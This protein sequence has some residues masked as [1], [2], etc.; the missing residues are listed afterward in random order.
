MLLVLWGMLFMAN[1]K[2]DN[3]INLP[4]KKVATNTQF[5]QTVVFNK[6]IESLEQNSKNI[7]EYTTKYFK[8]RIDYSSPFSSE[9]KD[10][11]DSMLI[12]REKKVLNSDGAKLRYY[13]NDSHLNTSKHKLSDKSK[14]DSSHITTAKL[15]TPK[16]FSE[17]K[18]T[19]K[20][21]LDS[22]KPKIVIIIDDIANTKQLND[23]V[24]IQNIGLKLTPSIFPVAQNNTKMLES[25]ANL[26]FFMVHLP[27]EA[28][29]YKDELDTISIY[30][31]EDSIKRKIARIKQILPN[32]LYIN[33]HTGSKFTEQRSNMEFL[34]SVLD[35]HNINFVDSRTTQNTTLPE[36]A[37]AQNRLILY[38]DVFIDNQ[39]DSHSLMAQINEGVK[40]AKARGYA[41]LIAHPHKETLN[42]IKV[43]K[44]SVLK[45]VDVIYLNELDYLLKKSNISQYAQVLKSP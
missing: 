8:K 28:L 3:V 45:E 16:P 11:Q 22:Y 39:L 36:I 24:A 12:E 15:I 34:L 31:S 14:S 21:V 33:N 38:R 30:D 42:A 37:K 4:S 32:T 2:A 35:S 7:D 18:K 20:K 19:Y 40:I 43:A 13:K 44:N 6:E 17:P 23:I 1:L 5:T 10:Y 29:A 27:L 26:D 41:I 25:V 9:A